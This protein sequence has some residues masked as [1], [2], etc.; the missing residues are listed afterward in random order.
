MAAMTGQQ[1]PDGL[2]AQQRSVCREKLR[3]LG[4]PAQAHPEMGAIVWMFGCAIVA[5]VVAVIICGPALWAMVGGA[6]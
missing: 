6:S 1:E 3:G 5:L 4:T 2:T